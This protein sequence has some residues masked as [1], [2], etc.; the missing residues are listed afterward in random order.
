MLQ[1]PNKKVLLT[2]D[3]LNIRKFKYQKLKNLYLI[4][5]GIFSTK[6]I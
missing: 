4:Q 5:N 1:T 2:E 3:K 6:E